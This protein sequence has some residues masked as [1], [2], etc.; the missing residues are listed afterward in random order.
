MLKGSWGFPSFWIIPRVGVENIHT[1][2]F[3]FPFCQR[4]QSHIPSQDPTTACTGCPLLS[5]SLSLTAQGEEIET[6]ALS[7]E[8]CPW[9]GSEEGPLLPKGPCGS[10]RLFTHNRAGPRSCLF[11]NLGHKHDVHI[12]S[13]HGLLKSHA[14]LIPRFQPQRHPVSGTQKVTTWSQLGP[15]SSL[16]QLPI[17]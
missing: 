14:L 6:R 9:V 13:V 1:T 2:Y 4:P 12:S 3:C 7:R 5:Q 11:S 16:S 17:V 15:G 8:K 10:S